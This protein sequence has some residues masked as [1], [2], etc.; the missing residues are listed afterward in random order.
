MLV[1]LDTDAW[2]IRGLAGT[3]LVYK[4]AA[5][6]SDKGTDL[7]AVENVAKYVMS[8]LGTLGVGLDHC[9]VSL[10]TFYPCSQTY[11]NS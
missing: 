5:A 1:G 9:H 6:L 2:C 4:A 11:P 8:R 7:D 10:P 3:I